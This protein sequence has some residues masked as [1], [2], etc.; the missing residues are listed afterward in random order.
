MG[1]VRTGNSLLGFDWYKEPVERHKT[2]VGDAVEE[3]VRNRLW[4][5]GVAFH[6]A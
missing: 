1:P 3:A 5:L 6:Q 4:A 2:A